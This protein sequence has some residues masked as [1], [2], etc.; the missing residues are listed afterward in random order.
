MNKEGSDA[1]RIKPVHPDLSENGDHLLELCR[2]QPEIAIRMDS[3][4]L[5]EQCVHRPAAGEADVDPAV[6]SALSSATAESAP[7]T[8]SCIGSKLLRTRRSEPEISAR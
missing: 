7:I 4:L 1:P 8:W 2:V 6:S 5:A 3:V